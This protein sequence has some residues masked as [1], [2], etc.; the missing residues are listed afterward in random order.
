MSTRKRANISCSQVWCFFH[1]T[2][3]SLPWTTIE[4]VKFFKTFN[5]RVFFLKKKD[6]I[7]DKKIL[8]FFEVAKGNKSGLEC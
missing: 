6:E 3:A 4:I 2:V 8:N 1:Q 7:L 5:D